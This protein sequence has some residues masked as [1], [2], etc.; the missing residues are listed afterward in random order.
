MVAWRRPS[1]QRTLGLGPATTSV[2]PKPVYAVGSDDDGEK[3]AGKRLER[4]LIDLDVEGVIVVARWY[5]G[6]LLGPVR[7]THI[8][9]VARDAIRKWKSRQEGQAKRQKMASR[10]TPSTGPSPEVVDEAQRAKLARQLAERDNSIV[11]LRGLLAEKTAKA[12][13]ESGEKSSQISPTSTNPNA[14]PPKK[15]DYS[16]MPLQRLRQLDKAR[17]AT[18]AFIL[19]QIDLAEE[20]EHKRQVNTKTDTSE[21]EVDKS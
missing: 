15:V 18:I 8:E 4:V 6:I 10:E 5:G 13:Q 21:G 9:M 19:K 11:I 20:E 17:D 3:Y 2:A 14:S 1:A 12:Q 16:G 7:F